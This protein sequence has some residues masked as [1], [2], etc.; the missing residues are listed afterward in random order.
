MPLRYSPIRA[1]AA[2]HVLR[3]G[4][5]VACARRLF[6]A[7]RLLRDDIDSKNHYE[8]LDVHPDASPAEIKKSFYSLSKKHHPD[9]NRHDPHASRRFM[10]ISEAYGVLSHAD[11]RLKYDR[12]VLRRHERHG[13]LYHQ[14]RAGSYHSTGPAGGRPPSGLSK[15]RGTFTGPPPSFFRSGGWG[16]H[17]AKRKAAHEESTG[18]AGG[19]TTSGGAGAEMGGAGGM[20]PGQDPFGHQE[21]VP[22]FDKAGHE[23]T[24]HWV[25][26]RRAAR[27]ADGTRIGPD[28][29]MASNF[30]VILGV[31]GFAVVFPYF[32]LG[33]WSG[34][35]KRKKSAEKKKVD[36]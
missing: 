16:A 28:I 30:F 2:A 24:G 8:T 29:G 20:G 9:H 23:R 21:D 27:R 15:R 14:H 5:G 3:D 18:G 32:V 33:G 19:G 22:H 4:A 12:D 26:Q 34:K 35:Q 6:H 13:H 1:A 36:T 31:L 11:K 10:R 25:D 7:S 17:G